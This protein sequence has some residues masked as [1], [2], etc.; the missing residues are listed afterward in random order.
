MEAVAKWDSNHPLSATPTPLPSEFPAIAD[1]VELTNL[2]STHGASG[3][4]LWQQAD[5]YLQLIGVAG[6]SQETHLSKCHQLAARCLASKQAMHAFVS[7]PQGSLY[8]AV[9]IAGR[10]HQA[11]SICFPCDVVELCESVT[12]QRFIA[13]Q[14]I[15]ASL[16]TSPAHCEQTT[17]PKS[18]AEPSPVT[19]AAIAGLLKTKLHSEWKATRGNKKR[20]VTI[21][22]VLILLGACPWPHSITCKVV[23]EP[24]TRRYVAAPFDGK[25]EQSFVVPGQTIKAGDRLCSLHGG[26]LHSELAVL[27]AKHAQSK[28]RLMAALSTGDHSKAEYERLDSEYLGRE[29]DLLIERRDRLDICSPMDGVIINGDLERAKDAPVKVGDQLF[30]IASL[31][32]MVAEISIPESDVRLV[33]SEMDTTIYFESSQGETLQTKIAHVHLRSELRQDQ[34]VFVADAKIANSQGD[35]RPGMSGTAKVW[36]GY[37]SLGWIWLRQPFYAVRTMIG[38]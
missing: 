25:I 16:G 30:E 14:R 33:G 19:W 22:L 17:Q 24:L 6:D 18:S 5:S 38:W 15:A 20:Y 8:L 28:Q 9:P 12:E 31:D 3:A 1:S 13:A 26:E 10:D 21:S 37:R 35:L 27:Q 32:E 29:I 2:F 11:I 36:T 23:C 34:S 4:S 7:S